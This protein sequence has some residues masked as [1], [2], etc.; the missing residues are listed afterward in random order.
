MEEVEIIDAAHAA[1]IYYIQRLSHVCPLSMQLSPPDL[2]R[3]RSGLL[4]LSGG[5]LAG[6][7]LIEVPAANGQITSVLVHTL[8]EV[9]DVRLARSWCLVL[10]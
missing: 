7:Q 10:G 1:R 2:L 4:V 5:R 6:L 9:G 3:A 8:T